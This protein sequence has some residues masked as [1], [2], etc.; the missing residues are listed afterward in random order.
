[1]T[2]GAAA[3][4][5]DAWV[6]FQGAFEPAQYPVVETIYQRFDARHAAQLWSEPSEQPL[7][8]FTESIDLIQ[9]DLQIFSGA[10]FD[11]DALVRVRLPADPGQV[12]VDSVWPTVGATVNATWSDWMSCLPSVET[13]WAGP[14]DAARAAS[15]LPDWLGRT[16][17]VPRGLSAEIPDEPYLLYPIYVVRTVDAAYVELR[18]KMLRRYLVNAT[19]LYFASTAALAYIAHVCDRA[20]AVIAIIHTFM[21]HRHSRESAHG[22]LPGSDSNIRNRRVAII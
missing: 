13:W 2:Y 22:L 10:V 16:W 12:P 3:T 19:R 5:A 7:W 18:V 1:M 9:S 4:E 11:S 17:E 14:S 8:M 20:S 6:P 15:V 21:T